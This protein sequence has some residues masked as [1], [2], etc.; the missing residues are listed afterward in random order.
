LEFA[1]GRKFMLD[2]GITLF[3]SY[4]PSRQNTNTGK[5]KWDEWI[6]VFGEVREAL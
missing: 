4:H 1:H 6:N 2:S 5:L 3:A